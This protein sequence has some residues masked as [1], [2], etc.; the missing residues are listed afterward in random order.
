MTARADDNTAQTYFSILPGGVRAK[1][2]RV[3]KADVR[4]IGMTGCPLVMPAVVLL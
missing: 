1:R 3:W 2:S 4:D